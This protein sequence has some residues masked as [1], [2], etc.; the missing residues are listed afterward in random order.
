MNRYVNG[1][2][3]GASQR[4]IRAPK[5]QLFRAMTLICSTAGAAGRLTHSATSLSGVALQG[6]G[7][8]L[9]KPKTLWLYSAKIPVLM[10]EQLIRECG[11]N[12][13]GGTVNLEL[14]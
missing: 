6:E 3:P 2:V 11:M 5:H 4:I 13:A 1:A 9:N 8:Q 10:V 14:S 12:V 7:T